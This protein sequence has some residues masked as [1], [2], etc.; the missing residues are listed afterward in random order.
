MRRE[1]LEAMIDLLRARGARRY[2][3]PRTSWATSSASPTAS[4]SCTRRLIVD[5]SLEDLKRRVQ[6]R[7]ARGWFDEAGARESASR[8][9]CARAPCATVGS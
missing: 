5:V 2:C 6:K 3:S 7:F 8:V 9:S 4:G 1:F